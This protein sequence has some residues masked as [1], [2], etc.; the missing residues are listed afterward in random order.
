MSENKP[1]S[2]A[3]STG[4]YLKKTG[5]VGK[6]DNVRRFWED[7][8]T[9]L[10]IRKYLRE[11]VERKVRK[12]ERLRI[13]DI[14]CGSG[15]GFELLMD[16]TARDVG[17]YEYAVEV[18]DSEIL[19]SYV[20]V[21]INPD[22]LEQAREHFNNNEKVIFRLG[23]FSGGLPVKDEAFD[24]YLTS[25]GTLAHN[26]DDTT[27]E[28]LA[29]IAAHCKGRA[30]VVCD[31]LGMYSYE[32][33]DLWTK[34]VDEETFM[35]Y[36]ISYIYPP[37]ER[38]LV[39]IQSFP[40][41]LTSREAAMRII[42]RAGEKAGVEIKT[43][44][45]FDR[46][47]LVGRHMDTADYNKHCPAIREVVNS[48]LEPNTRTDLSALVV[49]YIPKKGFDELNR[50][51]E[52]FCMCWN[53]LVK[54]TMEFLAEYPDNPETDGDTLS[55]YVFYPDALKETIVTMKKVIYSTGKLPGDARANIIEPQLAYAL[56]K[57]EMD[58][59][60]GSGVG[61]GLGAVLEIIK[62]A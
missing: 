39:E 48:L 52:G 46:S 45:F 18:M 58:L 34:G 30:L 44:R 26:H 20:G 13:L 11:L 14:G 1:Y 10:F 54:H 23:D 41:R 24:V 19:E 33:Q 9:R 21:D 4:Q 27:V 60:P 3:V 59:Q 8:V 12:L 49:D 57:L 56:R 53:T 25:Y 28:I 62:E 43:R 2:E 22:L 38:E 40:L 6:Y 17:I 5:L 42:N 29:D 61:H 31:W 36:R 55:T 47:I 37:E 16:M 7:E 32:W 50:F 51:F 35:D 15:D